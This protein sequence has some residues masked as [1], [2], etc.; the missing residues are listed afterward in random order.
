[1]TPTK[2][3]ETLPRGSRYRLAMRPIALVGLLALCTIATAGCCCPVGAFAPSPPPPAPAPM[4]MPPAPMPEPPSGPPSAPP[5]G[6]QVQVGGRNVWPP[7]G[8]GCD[9]YIACCEAARSVNS[10][11]GL[12]C[13]LSVS[14]PPVDCVH[15]RAQIRQMITEMGSAPPPECAP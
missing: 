1:V 2:T 3:P 14:T 5:G 13:Q 9:R 15:A 10:A 11:I 8:P 6:G 7:V 12:A 4:P